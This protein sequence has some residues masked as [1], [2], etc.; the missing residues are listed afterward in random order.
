[1]LTLTPQ[2]RAVAALVLG[3]LTLTGDTFRLAGAVVFVFG[4]IY[5]RDTL[6]QFLASLVPVAVAFAAWFLAAPP[7]GTG[8]A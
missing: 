4:D 6:G 8:S 3:F 2:A 7:A 1:M 5:P